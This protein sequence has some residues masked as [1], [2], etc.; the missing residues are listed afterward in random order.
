MNK[1]IKP[2]P[3]ETAILQ[4]LWEAQPR[5]VKDIHEALSQTR[6]VGYTT[7]LKQIQRMF[8]KG[9]VT[10][11]RGEGKSYDY[12]AAVGEADTKARL[13]DRFVSTAFEGSVPDL[14]MHALG[15]DGASS[16]DIEK[17]REFL[18]SLDPESE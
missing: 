15:R 9:L 10:R 4:V 17:I 7:T 18:D 16:D 13:F 2:S 12:S 1:A 11:E 3:G 14:V 8:E 5:S 6:S